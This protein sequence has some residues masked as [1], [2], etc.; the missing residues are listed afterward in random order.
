METYKWVR[1]QV[2]IKFN[3]LGVFKGAGIFPFDLT[4]VLDLLNAPLGLITPEN[5][6]SQAQQQS[7]L[8]TL[9]TLL[10]IRQLDKQKQ[11]LDIR[12]KNHT[13]C[14]SNLTAMTGATILAAEN[15][16]LCTANEKQKRKHASHWLT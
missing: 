6:H 1:L 15:Q 16:A 11:M 3:I 14:L 5:K 7:S 13:C 4:A 10:T 8:W 12:L 2:S 9:Q